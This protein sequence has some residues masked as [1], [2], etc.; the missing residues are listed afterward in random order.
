MHGDQTLFE[1][2][3]LAWYVWSQYGSHLIRYLPTDNKPLRWLDFPAIH[4]ILQMYEAADMA[5]TLEKLVVI[6]NAQQS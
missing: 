6:F 1:E 3:R 2:N 4:A 5:D